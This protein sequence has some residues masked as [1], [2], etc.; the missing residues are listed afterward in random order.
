MTRKEYMEEL[1]RKLSRLPVEEYESAMRYY[2]EYFDDAGEENEQQAIE[3]LGT[4]NQVASQLLADY[5]IKDMES[6]PNGAGRGMRSVWV[7]VASILA[8][9]I[10]LPLAVAFAAVAFVLLICLGV[11]WLCLWIVALTFALSGIALGIVG[12]WALFQELFTGLFF[13]GCGLSCIGIGLAFSV[14]VAFLSKKSFRGIAK[15][16]YSLSNRRKERAKR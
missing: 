12:I 4:P 7:V 9:P 15:G 3:S 14:F 8:A 11:V 1:H 6:S 10:A 2:N 16:I 13:L 5:A